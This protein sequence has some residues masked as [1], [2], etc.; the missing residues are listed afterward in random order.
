MTNTPDQLRLQQDL[1]PRKQ[2]GTNLRGGTSGSTPV[3]EEIIQA[4]VNLVATQLT[5]AGPDELGTPVLLGADPNQA[6]YVRLQPGTKALVTNQVSVVSSA[7]A[8]LAADSTRNAAVLVNMD[9][10]NPVWIGNT[11]VTSSTGYQLNAGNSISLATTAAIS[12]HGGINT[13]SVGYLVIPA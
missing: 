12:G 13:V 5:G 3:I 2:L 7:T 11:T 10:V 4:F 9:A 8:I 6:L 1:L